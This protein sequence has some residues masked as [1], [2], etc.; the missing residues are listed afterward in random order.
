MEQ[1]K[2]FEDLDELQD[3]NE[4]PIS[5]EQLEG[6]TV[7]QLRT[8][9]QIGL[10]EYEAEQEALY[11]IECRIRSMENHITKMDPIG[12]GPEYEAYFEKL[13]EERRAGNAQR[14]AMNRAKADLAGQSKILQA[15]ERLNC[16]AA[17]W[18]NTENEYQRR[19]LWEE[20]ELD[21]GMIQEL[22]R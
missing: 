11:R 20:I 9:R 15:T 17:K 6:V 2:L 13:L 12:A 19:K 10:A 8:D 7:E 4:E 1:W 21:L 3:M 14:L 16:N 5:W 18:A 22:I